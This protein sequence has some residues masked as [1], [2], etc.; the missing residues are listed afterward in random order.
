MTAAPIRSA[1]VLGAGTMGAQ[2]AAHLANAGV[3]TLLLDLTADVARDGLKRAAAL[4]PDPF[5][6][7]DAARAHHDRRLRRRPRPPRRRRLDRRGRRRAARRQAGAARASRRGAAA[8]HDRVVEHLGHSDRGARRRPERRLPAALA[9]HAL[10]QPAALPAAARG[11][12][13]RRTP[14]PRSSRASRAFADHR[15][16][17]GVVVAKDTPNFIANHIGLFGVVQTLRALESGEY[18]IEEI[19][20]ITGPAIGRPK[21][22]TFRTMDIA[23]IDV[24]GHVTRESRDAPARRRSGRPSRCRRSSRRWS[25]A[26]GSAR[27]P[28]KGS[29]GRNGVRDPDAR[30]RDARL[31][32]EAVGPAAALDAAK[33]IDDVARADP[34]A[35]P[36]TRQGRRVPARH[37][38]RRRSSTPRA[39]TP[40]DRALDRRCRS[41]DAVGLRLGARSVRDLGRD[42][43][44]Q[45]ARG[46]RRAGRCRRSSRTC[47]QRGRDRF[48]DGGRCRRRRPTCRFSSP[49]RIG[50]ASS[51]ATPAPAWSIS[52]TA[53][54]PSSSTRR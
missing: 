52:A 49:R 6:T 24:L 48:R 43:R 30:S 37:A 54:W 17:K 4:K 50:S 40:D 39:S 1:A 20:A 53:C 3:P 31:S 44:P 25:S 28:G 18:T 15:L 51:A 33:S 13:D 26:D 12:P 27:K 7:R 35:V 32:P 47:S 42:R 45:R 16:G 14:T 19:D 2:I 29:T 9:R 34:D 11:D 36:R 8:G 21:S 5:F 41:R 46:G 38:R 22:A 10:L 23:G